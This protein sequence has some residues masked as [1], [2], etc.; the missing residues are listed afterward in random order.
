MSGRRRRARGLYG[1][2]ETG[3]LPH[4]K[5]LTPRAVV[6]AAVIFVG[7]VAAC[8]AIT[9]CIAAIWALGNHGGFLHAFHI[10]LYVFGCVTLAMGVLGVGGVSPSHGLSAVGATPGIM[11]GRLPGLKTTSRADPDGTAVNATAVLL[12]TGLTLLVTASTT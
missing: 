1:F 11:A 7:Q 3:S 2:D 9:A 6:L 5:R 10:G 8:M 4:K 12:V